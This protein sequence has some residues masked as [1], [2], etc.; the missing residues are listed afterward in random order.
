MRSAREA[1]VSYGE[2]APSKQGA[3]TAHT[4][5]GNTSELRAQRSITSVPDAALSQEKQHPSRPVEVL[6]SARHARSLEE[7]AAAEQSANTAHTNIS[8]TRDPATRPGFPS[9]R[10]PA[11]RVGSYG[12][13]QSTADKVN[14]KS[15]ANDEFWNLSNEAVD[16]GDYKLHSTNEDWRARV[17]LS[18]DALFETVKDAKRPLRQAARLIRSRESDRPSRNVNASAVATNLQPALNEGFMS[19]EHAQHLVDMAAKGISVKE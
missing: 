17:L 5:K 8:S 1:H 18:H 3:I 13:H 15:R 4:S 7:A 16:S 11:P 9:A 2:A 12:R 19:P 6:K 10:S 14:T